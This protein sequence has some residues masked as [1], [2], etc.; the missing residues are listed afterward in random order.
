MAA[1][2]FDPT[3][4]VRYLDEIEDSLTDA[5]EAVAESIGRGEGPTPPATDE[6]DRVLANLDAGERLARGLPDQG[7]RLESFRRIARA[8]ESIRRA[9]EVWQERGLG[10]FEDDAAEGE[11]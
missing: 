11:A 6:L 8:A 2:D 10:P 3:T 7:E 9:S 4:R 5:V 1:G